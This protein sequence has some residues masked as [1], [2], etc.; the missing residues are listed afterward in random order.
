MSRYEYVQ[1]N[2]L[3]PNYDSEHR[4]LGFGKSTWSECK[5]QWKLAAPTI[6]ASL[7]QYMFFLVAEVMA[8]HLSKFDLAALA[9]A[10][11]LVRGIG[12]GFML[13]MGTALETFCGQAFGARQFHMLGIYM[14]RSIV[15]LSATAVLLSI[16]CIFAEPIFK[17]LGQSTAIATKS[18]VLLKWM[19]PQLFAFAINL[20]VEKF[21]H[22]QSLI[23]P[24]VWISGGVLIFHCV[25]C[26]ITAFTFKLGLLGIVMTHNASCWLVA[27]FQFL[28]VILSDSCKASWTGFTLSAFRQLLSFLRLS[29]FSAIMVFLQIWYYQI[30][31]FL[32]GTLDD[33]EVDIDALSIS[34]NMILLELMIPLGFGVAISIRVAN[35]LGAGNAEAACFSVFVAVATSA[36]ISIFFAIIFLLCKNV[37]GYLFTGS[38]TVAESV[39]ALVPFLT[40]SLLLNGIQAVLSGVATG[41]GSQVY[42]AYVN[43]ISCYLVGL[44]LGILIC[45]KFSLGITGIWSGMIAGTSMQCL[46]LFYSAWNTNWNEQAKQASDYLSAWRT[47]VGASRCET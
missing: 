46:I 4:R 40:A 41:S 33:P 30:L 14:Q 36:I 31:V 27:I 7:L 28:Y 19:L 21:L 43:I 8:G 5:A 17:L 45:Y 25:V 26:W 1:L 39:S 42:V 29:I 9:I 16:P 12:Y 18:G 23:L 35:E 15:I 22:A 38:S 10:F 44:P 47:D 11:T 34:I 13:G 6:A 32:A 24:I 20:S 3:L 2:S 37:L